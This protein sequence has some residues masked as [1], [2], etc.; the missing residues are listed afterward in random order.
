MF[1]FPEKAAYGTAER[2]NATRH[3]HSTCQGQTRCLREGK[4]KLVYALL[5]KGRAII[6]GKE[7]YQ[8]CPVKYYPQVAITERLVS[9]SMKQTTGPD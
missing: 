2:G 3:L 5:R 6:L 1:H 9:S 7:Q 4:H 8:G